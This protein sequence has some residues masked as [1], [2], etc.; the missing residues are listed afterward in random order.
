MIQAEIRRALADELPEAVAYLVQKFGGNQHGH[1]A[2][3]VS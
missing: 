1:A 2:K 3:A